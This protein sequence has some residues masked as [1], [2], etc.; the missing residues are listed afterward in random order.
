MLSRPSRRQYERSQGQHVWSHRSCW[1]DAGLSCCGVFFD[2]PPW[3]T[4]WQ[5][6]AEIANVRSNS[7]NSR[8]R[9]VAIASGHA[10][11]ER[12]PSRAAHYI[13]RNEIR[14]RAVPPHVRWA[15]RAGTEALSS[16]TSGPRRLHTVSRRALRGSPIPLNNEHEVVLE[17][18]TD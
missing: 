11:A 5:L 18:Q 3:N 15:S 12:Y 7:P 9:N 17:P 2:D 4:A 16:A 8:M 13:R 14:A 10:N 1:N 6:E